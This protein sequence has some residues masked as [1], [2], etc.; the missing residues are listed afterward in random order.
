MV[1]ASV[2][3][4]ELDRMA[5]TAATPASTYDAAAAEQAPPSATAPPGCS[6]A[7]GVDVIDA[8]ADHLPVALTDHYLVLK[9]R[10]LL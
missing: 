4:P 7:L 5:A 6:A 9:A 3:D 2:R 1:L 10:G 8:D